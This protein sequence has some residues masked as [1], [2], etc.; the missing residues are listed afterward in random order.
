MNKLLLAAVTIACLLPFAG[1]AVHIDD[2]LFLWPAQHIHETPADPYGFPVNWYGYD[3]PMWRVTQNPPLTSYYLAFAALFVG[4]GS[5]PLHLAMILPAIAVV[6]GTYS[7]ARWLCARP[8]QAAL[9]SIF[10]PVFLISATTLM[11]DVMMLAFWIWAIVLWLR[12]LE[13][14]SHI[15]LALSGLLMAA[16]AMSK[17][18]GMTLIPLL[19]CYSIIRK[20]S[21]GSWAVHFLV[22]AA[23]LAAYQWIT[24]S[25]Y[26]HGLLSDAASYADSFRTF[27][28][29]RFLKVLI[30]IIFTGGCL[31]GTILYVPC[32]WGRKELIVFLLIAIAGGAGILA[33]PRLGGFEFHD[34]E[35]VRWPIVLQASLFLA[36]GIHLL[37]LSAMDLIRRRDPQ[38]W[39]LFLWIAGTFL[40][41]ALINWSVNGRTL[42]PLVPALAILIMRRLDERSM[43][44]PLLLIPAALVALLVACADLSLADAGKEAALRIHGKYSG[45]RQTWF[46]GHWGF[47]YYMEGGGAKPIDAY[48]QGIK[49]GDV[50]VVPQNNTNTYRMDSTWF[51]LIDTIR[52]QPFRWVTTLSG[53]LGAGFYSDRVGPL[54]YSVGDVPPERYLIFQPKE[55]K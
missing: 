3:S 21:V 47:Q 28:D 41:A 42:L 55:K 18:F 54:P 25:I 8:V 37:A 34:P 2:P 45:A 53:P 29:E 23:F 10:T 12:G 50:I 9:I 26:G 38:A 22:P 51:R 36:G 46:Q 48:H 27:Q 33:L 44:A 39:L 43:S 5:L 20:R 35:G 6:L 49:L 17:Y 14:N 24:G 30:G 11:C 15:R 40:F 7:V 52:V 19:L 16:A 32:L 31:A 13:D 4:W 1:K